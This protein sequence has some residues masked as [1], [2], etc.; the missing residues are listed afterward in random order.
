MERRSTIE[1]DTKETK[2]RVSLNLDG[3]GRTNV[4]TG[5][6]F[7]NHMITLMASHGFMDLE[8]QA[9]GDIEIDYH[10][11]VEDVGICLGRAIREA[12]GSRKGIRRFGEATVPM[13]EALA[14]VSMDLSNRPFLAY[15]VSLKRTVTGAFDINLAGEFFRAVVNHS[16]M[17]LHVD[18][19]RGDDPHH[20]CEAV[21]KAFGRAL[22]QASSLEPRL[23]GGI[24][25]TKGLL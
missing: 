22:D 15:E 1:R 8:I 23:S 24:P 20:G 12:L 17:T 6:P 16:G 18:L 2:I 5:I 19:I 4:D 10:H 11:T 21:F 9:K 7:L 14:R 3:A 13:D 25:S